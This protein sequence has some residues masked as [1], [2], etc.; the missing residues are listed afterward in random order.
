LAVNSVERDA[1]G[2][3]QLLKTLSLIQRRLHPQVRRP[4]QNTFCEG[5]DALYIDFLDCGGVFVDLRQR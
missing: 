3:K 4:R 5:Q 2:E 1:V